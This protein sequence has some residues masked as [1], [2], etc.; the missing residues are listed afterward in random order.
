MAEATPDNDQNEGYQAQ[1][2]RIVRVQG[3]CMTASGSTSAGSS[4]CN[5]A[6]GRRSILV[7]PSVLLSDMGAVS[8]VVAEESKVFQF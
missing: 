4:I 1:P 2:K 6:L 3:R 8:S 5:L 7:P